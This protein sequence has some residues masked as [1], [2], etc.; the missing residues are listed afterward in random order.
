MKNQK[1][2]VVIMLI[3]VLLLFT[4]C[5]GKKNDYTQNTDESTSTEVSTEEETTVEEHTD[6]KTT[7]EEPLDAAEPKDDESQEA[8]NEEQTEI[9]TPELVWSVKHENRLESVAVSPSEQTV[10]V[11]EFMTAY[12]YRLAD[13][14]L[15][16]VFLFNHSAED[17]GFSTDGTILG[18][19]L[20]VYGTVLTDVKSGKEI[21]QLHTGFNNRLDFSPNGEIIATGNRKGVVWLWRINDGEQLVNKVVTR[22]QN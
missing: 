16:D 19:G 21:R 2:T 6:E 18:A 17:M 14:E 15:L 11:G 13:G 8:T 20:G 10:A 4:A 7:D 1:I 5:N 22:K 12:T 3:A 9:E